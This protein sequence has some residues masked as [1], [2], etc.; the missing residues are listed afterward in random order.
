MGYPSSQFNPSGGVFLPMSA[1]LDTQNG[2]FF[3]R[4]GNILHTRN[5]LLYKAMKS[6]STEISVVW[7]L[8]LSLW[9]LLDFFFLWTIIAVVL[10]SLDSFGYVSLVLI[11]FVWIDRTLVIESN[12]GF[13]FA[14]AWTCRYHES[15]FLLWETPNGGQSELK[16]RR[17]ARKH[18]FSI[19]WHLLRL[20]P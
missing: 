10:K 13:F 8:L 6:H 3:P 15:I 17:L 2:L 19:F 18:I 12:W 7:N 11:F 1:E 5:H 20:C 4:R 9:N 16:Y 14:A